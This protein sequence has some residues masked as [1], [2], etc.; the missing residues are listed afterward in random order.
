MSTDFALD[1][2]ENVDAYARV[3]LQWLQILSRQQKTGRFKF[4]VYLE[5]GR[6]NES[7]TE[8]KVKNPKPAK[9]R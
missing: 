1:P 7:E 5:N 4:V 8:T 6:I 2:N 9:S 3:M